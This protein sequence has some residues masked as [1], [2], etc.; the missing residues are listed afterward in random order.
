M[1][2]ITC[3]IIK[4]A[5]N[6]NKYKTVSLSINGKKK[7]KSVHKLVAEAFILNPNNYPC[8]NHIDGNK[9]NNKADNLEW[10]TYKY[11]TSEAIRLGNFYFIKKHNR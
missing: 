6:G 2:N 8:I 1:R 11:N 10:C 9:K 7:T 3:K 5:N 4:Q